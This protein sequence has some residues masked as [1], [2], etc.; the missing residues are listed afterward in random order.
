[1]R[2]RLHT[3]TL[4]TLILTFPLAALANL[5]GTQTL[6]ASQT[7]SFDTG[8]ASTSGGDVLWSG[9]ALTPQGSA[10]AY[11]LSSIGLTGSTGFSALSQSTLSGFSSFFTKTAISASSLVVNNIFAVHTIGGNYAAALVTAASG[12]SITFQFVTY[13]VVS[14]PNIT[15]VQNN[16][17]NIPAGFPN[18]GI[19]QGALFYIVG[20]GLASSTPPLALQNPNGASLPTALN[21]ATVK[22][23]ASGQT[24]TPAFYYAAPT[25]LGLVLPSNTPIG[26][27][28]VTVSYNSQTSAPYTIQVVQSAFGIDTYYGSGTGL[29]VAVFTGTVP[30]GGGCAQASIACY[31]LSIPP[32]TSIQ[33]YGTGLGADPKSSRDSTYV[34]VTS[35]AADTINGLAAIYV[36]GVPATIQYQGASGYPGLNQINVLIPANAPT[37]C[38]VSV[39]GVSANGIPT[40]TITL[41][42]GTGTCSDPTYGTSGTQLQTLGGQGSVSTGVLEVIHA[43]SPATSGSGTSTNDEGAAIFTNSTGTTYGGSSQLTP[44]SCSVTQALVSTGTVTTPTY[45]DAGTITLTGPSGSPV[46]LADSFSVGLYFAQLASGYIPTTGGAFTFKGTG[47][48]SVGPLTATVNFPNPLLTWTNQSASSAVSRSAGLTVTWSGGASGTYVIIGGSSASSTA[49]GSFSC[50]A[51]V[52]AGQLTVPSYILEALPAGNG[53]VNVINETVPTSFTATGLNYGIAIGEVEYS[54]NSTYN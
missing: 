12:T 47:G 16:Y 49:S 24:I 33:L 53:G 8:T 26:S 13:G 3:A 10:T 45:L 48:A 23:T 31:T 50:Y 40:N 15:A 36:G 22:I 7:F 46:S 9:T 17:S 51:P 21:G 4:A 42:I 54:V 41:P 32:N 44:G 30:A 38:N 43:T 1:M 25:A 34:P 2:I 14:G 29:G 6:T 19:A 27:A 18:S 11:N 35:A 20:T 37:G 39:V 52:S 28:Q 5:T